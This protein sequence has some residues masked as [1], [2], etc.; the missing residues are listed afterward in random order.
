MFTREEL[1]LIAS[2]CIK[3]D[4]ICISDEVY[5]WLVYPGKEHLRIASLPG[6]LYSADLSLLLVVIISNMTMP[7]VVMVLCYYK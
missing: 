2:L 7:T 5:E 3:Y 6:T 1:E 4:V